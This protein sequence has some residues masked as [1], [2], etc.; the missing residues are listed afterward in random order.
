MRDLSVDKHNEAV[1]RADAIRYRNLFENSNDAMAT[2]SLDGLFTSI[3]RTMET[4]LD[5][6][7]EALIGQ[8]YSVVAT[9]AS[10][11]QWEERT[12]RAL[13]GER[14]PRIFET[15][16]LLKNGSIVPIE[17]RT[18]FIHDPDG[19]PIGFEGTFRNIT[20]RKQAEAAMRQAK[21]AAEVANQ[22]KSQF[23]ANISH[24]LRTPLNAIIGYSEMLIEEVTGLSQERFLP[25]LRN[26]RIAGKHL[27]QLINDILDISR[28][29]AGRMPLTL[30]TFA[31]AQMVDAVIT[32]VQP[33]AQGNANT[34]VVRYAPDLGTMRADAGKVRQVL[35]NILSNACKFTECGAILCEVRRERANDVPWVVFRIT[36]TGI[37]I[38]PEH[39]ETIF[40]AFVQADASTTRQ[41]GGTGLGLAISQRFCQMMGGHISVESR[42]GEG[43][44]FSVRLPVEAPRLPPT[45]SGQPEN[46][47]AEERQHGENPAGGR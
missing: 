18:G 21:E 1:S 25:D 9:P 37:G 31:I 27:L 2:I 39:L 32:T 29:E 36:D 5:W 45:A 8:H 35:G 15:E 43:S 26:I 28:I 23:L 30:E 38:A 6:P 22:A 11:A 13:A 47:A 12:R 40:Q 24:E 46:S 4:L 19:R 16:I 10:L 34:L 44:V 41:Y 20:A 33:L 14:L 17:C 7:R 3:N 42:L